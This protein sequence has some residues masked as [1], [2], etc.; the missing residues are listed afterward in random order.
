MGCA[1]P[2][3]MVWDKELAAA[4]CEMARMYWAH[5]KALASGA[6]TREVTGGAAP[7]SLAGARRLN[8]LV[9]KLRISPSPRPA[10]DR[11]GS[12]PIP[13]RAGDFEE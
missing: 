10:A 9:S 6:D 8:N 11:S 4:Y 1:N 3:T 5:W 13:G 7:G 2:G 12:S